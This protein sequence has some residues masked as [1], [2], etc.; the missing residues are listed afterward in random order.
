VFGQADL[1]TVLLLMLGGCITVLPLALFATAAQIVPMS[2]M[3]ILQYIGPTLQFS[4]G[5]LMFGE[6]LGINRAA[7]FVLVWIGCGIFLLTAGQSPP[8]ATPSSKDQPLA[9]EVI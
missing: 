4:L 2:M 9:G 6:P 8:S 3:G 7:G 1:Q 5:V